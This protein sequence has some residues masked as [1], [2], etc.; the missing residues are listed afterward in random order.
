MVS[1]ELEHLTSVPHRSVKYF[2][3]VIKSFPGV[4]YF[5]GI[6]IMELERVGFEMS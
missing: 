5:K 2:D 4:S 3:C 6:V 1:F